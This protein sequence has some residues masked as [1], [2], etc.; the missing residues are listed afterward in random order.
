M[1]LVLYVRRALCQEIFVSK[2]LFL[3]VTSQS[4]LI[5]K[6][7]SGT[8]LRPPRV[9]QRS[10]DG[11]TIDPEHQQPTSP[12]AT[13]LPLLSAGPFLPV[14]RKQVGLDETSKTS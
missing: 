6:K 7:A 3:Y 13:T 12:D 10:R 1:D 8:Y 9:V 11:T 2:D 4:A 14:Y 5:D